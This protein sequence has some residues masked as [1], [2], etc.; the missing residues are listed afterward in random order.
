MIRALIFDFDGVVLDTETAAY[1]S[2]QAIFTAYGCSLTLAKWVESVCSPAPFDPCDHLSEQL[3]WEVDRSAIDHEQA[4]RFADLMTQQPVLPGLETYLREA[5][6][7]G[8]GTGIA[9]NSPRE[10]VL[11]HLAGAGL[12]AHFDVV[13]CAE[14]VNALK[15]AP[16]LYR[17]VLRTLGLLPNE[18]IAM[19][20]SPNGVE[21]AK[22]A[23]LFCV[24][25]PNPITSGLS[26]ARA[27]MVLSSLNDV[28]LRILMVRADPVQRG[29]L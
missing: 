9:S 11:V 15:P 21:A 24:A 29:T 5:R 8:L 1:R 25:L 19:E 18:A 27:D 2:W 6:A 14:D 3:G 12:A 23:G 22:A 7:L 28:P 17:A 16:D 10:Y 4:R 26:F 20:D 13:K